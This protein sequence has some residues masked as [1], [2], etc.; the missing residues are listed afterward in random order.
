MVLDPLDN[1]FW[2][3]IAGTRGG[4]NRLQILI[5]LSPRPYN[6]NQIAQKLKLDYKTIRH[7]LEILLSNGIIYAS[8]EARYGELYHLHD[9]VRPKVK[10][11][12]ERINERLNNEK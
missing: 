12:V 4:P 7:H 9:F 10:Q 5:L 6:A 8:K 11:F 1:L 3:I 2:H